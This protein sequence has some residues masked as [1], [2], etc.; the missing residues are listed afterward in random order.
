M[1]ISV[2]FPNYFTQT[3]MGRSNRVATQIKA[4]EHIAMWGKQGAFRLTPCSVFS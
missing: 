4:E 2:G 3:T 1:M